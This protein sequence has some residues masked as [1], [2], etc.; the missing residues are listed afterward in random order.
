MQKENPMRKIRIE[1]V[2]LNI[3]LKDS[4][5]VEKA[6]ELLK[7]ITGATPVRNKAKKA[8]KTFGVRKGL[9]IGAKVTLRREKAL[10]V[11]KKLLKSKKNLETRNFNPGNFAFGIEEYLTIPGMKYDPKIGILGLD[12]CVTLERP[13]FRVKRRKIGKSRIGSNH[14]ITKEETIDFAKKELGVVI[15]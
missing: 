11:L 5:G 8:A 1:K 14:R 2:T 7:R 10:E 15:L 4:S 12:V 9:E 3:G 13:G 6:Y